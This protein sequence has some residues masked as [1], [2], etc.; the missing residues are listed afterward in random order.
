MQCLD[1][2]IR[3]GSKYALLAGGGYVLLYVV[4]KQPL[5][6]RKIQQ[7]IPSL[8]EHWHDLAHSAQTILIL[9]VLGHLLTI[10]QPFSKVYTD[11]SAHGWAYLLLTFSLM[12]LFHDTYFYWVHR[13]AH[14]PKLF[15]LFHVVHHRAANP[16]P[17]S[18]YTVHALEAVVQFG[19]IP[20]L[21]FA[22]PI[23]RE[24]LI[25]YMT[26]H[27][28][29]DVYGH[30]GYELFPRGFNTHWLGRWI[31]TSTAHNMHHKNFRGNY[32]LYFLIWDR[33][34]GTLSDKHDAMF[35]RIN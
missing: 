20:I 6:Q 33:L 32:S 18:A 3:I 23:Q 11:V 27:F 35:E 13:L 9:G 31:N 15:K 25:L 4:L 22:I 14:H 2:A 34:M 24:A 7:R 12:F 21:A 10:A 28:I 30:S 5:L 29:H 26:L 17:L 16:T 19:V 1:M 8:K